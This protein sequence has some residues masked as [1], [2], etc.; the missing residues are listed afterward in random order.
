MDV[1]AA[2][3]I[4]AFSVH[5]LRLVLPLDDMVSDEQRLIVVHGPLFFHVT[6]HLQTIEREW[7][8]AIMIDV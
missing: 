7:A 8:T 4:T 5:P 6:I 1:V 3:C 2:V